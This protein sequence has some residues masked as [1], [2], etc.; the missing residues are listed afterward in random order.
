MASPHLQAAVDAARAAGEIHIAKFDTPFSVRKKGAVD[1]VTEVDEA[2]EAAIRKVLEKATPGFAVL[3]EEGGRT[4]LGEA[5]WIV[6]P[7]DGTTNFAHGIPVFCVSIALMLSGQL[8][9]G[10]VYDPMRD[11]LF[12][13]EKGGGAFL[14]S[15]PIRVSPRDDL[16]SSVLATGFAY[17]YRTAT[18]HNFTAFTNM[19]R[20]TRGVRRLGAAALDLAYVAKGRFDGFWELG[21]KPWDTAAGTLLIREAGGVVTDLANNTYDPFTADIAASNGL[22]HGQMLKVLDSSF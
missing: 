6:D 14:N 19:T 10:V 21:L 5:L 20:A 13:A 3:G 12:H 15:S 17:D 1:L 11:E 18:R 16:D 8:S 22:I 4:G 7:L 2:S 9:V